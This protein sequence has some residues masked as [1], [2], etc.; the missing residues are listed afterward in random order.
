[1]IIA[2]EGVDGVGKTTLAKKLAVRIGA[3]YLK[4]PDRTT[5][6]G[7][8]IDKVLRFQG[9]MSPEAFQA[10]QTVNRLEKLQTLREAADS[11]ISHV[12]CDRYTASGVVYGARDGLSRTWLENIHGAIPRARVNVLLTG[13]PAI[14]D[15]TRF[16][17]R[18]RERYEAQG[19]QSLADQV[20]AFEVYWS[21]QR[22]AYRDETWLMFSMGND[23]DE[24]AGILGASYAG[25][26]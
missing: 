4:F 25:V 9:T 10:L 5:P 11:R 22:E 14:I 19:V 20:A 12:V 3:V 8:C 1:M 7:A 15:A 23:A 6:S 18:V 24:L 17:G 2:I 21:I 16:E 13:D 26:L